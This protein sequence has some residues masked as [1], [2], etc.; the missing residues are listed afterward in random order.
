MVS[1][2]VFALSLLTTPFAASA[3]KPNTVKVPRASTSGDLTGSGTLQVVIGSGGNVSATTDFS[4][5]TPADIVGCLN[6]AG[7][8]TL[9]DC[10]TYTV[11]DTYYVETSNGICSFYNSSSP[12]NTDDY[13]GA[14]DYALTCWEHTGVIGSDVTFYTVEGMAYNF[15]GNG[16]TDFYYDVPGLPETSTDAL[17]FWRFVWGG[18]ETDVPAGHYRALLLFG[19]S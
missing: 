7:Q 10:A 19:S 14:Y 4:T 16:D 5:S 2:L 1:S 9:D 12:A 15:L 6:A 17:N 11:T 18:E 13:Y 3:A 8:F